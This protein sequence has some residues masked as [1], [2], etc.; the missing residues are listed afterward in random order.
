MWRLIRPDAVEVIND[1]RAR[2]ALRRYFAVM[3]KKLPARFQVC[4]RVAVN[5]SLSS[6]TKELWRAHSEGVKALR[7]ILQKMDSKLLGWK[8][9]EKPQISLLDLK[10][11]LARRILK[12]CCLCERRCGTNRADGE[13]GFCGVGPVSR[14]SSEFM[15]YGEEPELVPSYTI[16]FSGCTFKCQYCQ[17]W[18]ISQYPEEGVLVS[19][20]SIAKLIENA[21]REG[22]RNVNFVGGEPTPNLQ[23]ILEAL[24]LCQ[25]DIPSVWNS[26]M[27]LS[28]ES[29]ELLSGTQ[30]IY[31]TDFKYGNDKCAERYSQITRYFEIVARNHR[32]AFGDAELIIRHLV[33]PNH[34][35]CC[36]RPI[37]KWIAKN[38][39]P[40]T[41]VNIMDQY[42]ACYLADQFEEINRQLTR[43]EFLESIKIAEEVGLKNVI[44]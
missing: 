24:K 18:D 43:E 3:E 19:P 15:H 20:A 32:L 31:L 36:T 10:I 27:Y 9:L 23:T 17:N 2:S 42:R 12:S 16:F 29:M 30:D 6:D 5:V 34:L 13:R 14:I 38:L 22:A 1:K 7:N 39:D 40:M 25:A 4:K 41:R 8:D 26:N 21:A 35:N 44:T 28:V 37:L 33:L 11:E